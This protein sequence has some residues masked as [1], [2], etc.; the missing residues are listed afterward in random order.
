[1]ASDLTQLW[2][3]KNRKALLQEMLI[4]IS[5]EFIIYMSVR[6]LETN[7]AHACPQLF[8]APSMLLRAPLSSQTSFSFTPAEGGPPSEMKVVSS[9][10]RRA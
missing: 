8:Q 5:Y 9:F 4:Q 3:E 10:P 7:Q 2:F 6:L 1:M